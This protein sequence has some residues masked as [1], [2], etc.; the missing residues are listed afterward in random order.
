MNE[1][2][3]HYWCYEQTVYDS[4]SNKCSIRRWCSKCG[5]IQHTHTTGKWYESK[6]GPKEIFSMYPEGYDPKLIKL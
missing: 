2:C 5:V 3:D 1:K 6:V 4:T